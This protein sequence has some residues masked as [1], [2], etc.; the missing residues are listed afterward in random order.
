MYRYRRALTLRP[1]P[2]L[3][4]PFPPS[5]QL[6]AGQKPEELSASLVGTSL[7]ALV[8]EAVP[9]KRTL[10]LSERAAN[11]AARIAQLA[12]GDVLSGSVASVTD[13]G[14][15][16]DLRGADKKLHGVEGLCHVSE[17]SW[18]PVRSPASILTVGQEVRVKVIKVDALKNR[19]SL[20]LRQLQADPLLETLDTLMPAEG[21]GAAAAV[22]PSSPWP[23]GLL[24][25]VQAELLNEPGI[26]G[27]SLGRQASGEKV[28]SQDFELWL[29]NTAATG[30]Y[31][32]LARSGR[33]VCEIHVTTGLGREDMKAA[34][35]RVSAR[36]L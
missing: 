30:G 14:A 24:A 9:E 2:F 36:I 13:F 12:P 31:N 26:T 33:L 4:L 34:L 32:L 5:P 1:F 20:S 10:I 21:D 19:I 16:V 28:V 8:L 29:A 6:Q 23:S 25:S 15:F 11:V 35:K 22:E 18:D 27:V 7:R 17:L 3:P